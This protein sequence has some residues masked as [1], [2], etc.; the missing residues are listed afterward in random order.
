[1]FDDLGFSHEEAT[2]LEMK[3]VLHSKIIRYAKK[4]KQAELQTLLG[5]SQPRVSDLLTGKISKF[6]L[7][8]LVKYAEALN[9]RPEIKTHTPTAVLQVA[10]A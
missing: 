2:A 9:L 1:V 5:E 3:A 4:Y 8:T 6:S 7:E 10:R